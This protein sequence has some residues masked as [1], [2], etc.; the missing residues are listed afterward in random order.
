[1]KGR[2]VNSLAIPFLFVSIALLEG[3]ICL[4][5]MNHPDVPGQPDAYEYQRLAFNLANHKVFSIATSAPYEPSMFRSP[6]YPV[7]LALCFSLF[8][9]SIQVVRILQFCIFGVAAWILY[10]VARRVG[11]R[12]SGA[13]CASFLFLSFPPFI[14]MSVSLMTETLATFFALI[15]VYSLLSWKPRRL[16]TAMHIGLAVGVLALIRPSFC[17]LLVV[18]LPFLAVS[19]GVKWRDLISDLGVRCICFVICILPWSVRNYSLSNKFAPFGLG[20]YTLY[21]SAQQ[22]IGDVNVPVLQN[23]WDAISKEIKRR[24][25][26][27]EMASLDGPYNH[28]SQLSI[29]KEIII[30]DSYNKDAWPKLKSASFPQ[31]VK[32]VWHKQIALWG[33]SGGLSRPWLQKIALWQYWLMVL[34][35]IVGIIKGGVKPHWPLWVVPVYLSLMH[36]FFLAEDRYSLPARPFLVLYAGAGL[37]YVLNLFRRCFH[38]QPSYL[39]KSLHS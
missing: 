24:A 39:A 26:V 33:A 37:A 28:I 27:A 14:F 4:S 5:L 36:A 23:D 22:F 3:I 32:T 21:V 38:N 19:S 6:G 35:I 8:G 11:L 16:I 34:L 12:S 7:F 29:R 1:M 20:G 31:I 13:Y 10:L 18:L 17:L 25:Q 2:L 30:D 15:F 9:N